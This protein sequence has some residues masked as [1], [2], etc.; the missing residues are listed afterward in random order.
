MSEFGTHGTQKA[1]SAAAFFSINKFMAQ[2]TAEK[3]EALRIDLIDK[4]AEQYQ[5][6]DI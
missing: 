6:I 2:D 4:E 1:L 5:A 3:L